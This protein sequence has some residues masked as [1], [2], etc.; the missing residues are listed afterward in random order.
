MAIGITV[1][2]AGSFVVVVCVALGV[3]LGVGVAGGVTVAVLTVSLYGPALMVNAGLVALKRKS[4]IAGL[5][6]SGSA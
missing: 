1:Q 4:P 5:T 2:I 6:N 3:T